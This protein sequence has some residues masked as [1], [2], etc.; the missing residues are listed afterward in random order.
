MSALK[1]LAVASAVLM[2]ASTL[3]MAQAGGGAEPHQATRRRRKTTTAVRARTLIPV[4]V[5]SSPPVANRRG[6]CK[7]RFGVARTGLSCMSCK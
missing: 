4:R 3:A 2:G 1:V 7:A 6:Q 5:N